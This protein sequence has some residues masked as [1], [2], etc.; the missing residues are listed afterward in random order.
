VRNLTEAEARVLS[1]LLANTAGDERERLRQSRLPRSTYHA[2]RRRA[3][4][5]GWL[6][7]RYL[8]SPALF[9]FP[10]VSVTM[11]RPFADRGAELAE[12]WAREPGHVFGWVGSQMALGVFFHRSD[13][14]RSA[15]EVRAMEPTLGSGGLLFH[16]RPEEGGFPVYFDFEGL[17]AHLT[18]S[19]GTRAYPRGLP[20][21]P[22]EVDPEDP[23]RWNPRRNWAARELLVR[24]FAAE[25]QGRP[26]HLIGPFGL[27]FAQ[28]HLLSQGWVVHRVL[29]DPSRVPP[30]AGHSMD[31]VVLVTGT[32]RPGISPESMFV[33]LTRECRVFP[34]LYLVDSG[35]VLLGALGQSPGA[36]EPS[37]PAETDRRPVLPTLRL[38]LEGILV[39]EE[40][41]G[42]LRT[43]ADHRYD[44]MQP[45]QKRP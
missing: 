36:G 33:T 39:V 25:A 4:A 23:A 22:P 35:R 2:A 12:R 14:E 6:K 11:I 26:G 41:A 13:K 3:Y 10:Q 18:G 31:R 34:F 16:P 1:L 24:P 9:G 15:A 19:D 42:N 17:W 20:P 29:A 32:L 38:A 21:L 8:P 5:E 37:S 27:P 45:E 43:S 44:R 40:A 7:D 30:Y 28:K